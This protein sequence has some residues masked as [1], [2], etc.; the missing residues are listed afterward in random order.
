MCDLGYRYFVGKST[1]RSSVLVLH[2]SLVPNVTQFRVTTPTPWANVSLVGLLVN[3]LFKDSHAKFIRCYLP[4]QGIDTI[5]W[6]QAFNRLKSAV[7]SGPAD[8]ILGYGLEH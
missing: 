5:I 1:W 2:P 7:A 4:H 8:F 6:I 3:D